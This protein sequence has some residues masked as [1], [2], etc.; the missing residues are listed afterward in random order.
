MSPPRLDRLPAPDE[1]G[2]FWLSAR[3][4]E[5]PAIFSIGNRRSPH[6]GK[7]MV[8]PTGDVPLGPDGYPEA[9]DTPEEA[10]R[11]LRALERAAKEGRPC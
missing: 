5:A 1:F 6:R 10:L 9:F 2:N 7:Y 4:G 11:R 3:R 8:L